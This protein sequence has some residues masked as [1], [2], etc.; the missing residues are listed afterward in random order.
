MFSHTFS[1]CRPLN[2][3]MHMYI[4]TCVYAC[5]QRHGTNHAIY[6]NMVRRE[7]IIRPPHLFVSSGAARHVVREPKG[8]RRQNFGPSFPPLEG[9]PLSGNPRSTVSRR[10]PKVVLD[11]LPQRRERRIEKSR[12]K[13]RGEFYPETNNLNLLA[14][15]TT[16]TPALVFIVVVDTKSHVDLM[17]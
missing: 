8:H 9:S 10:G 7:T 1:F 4:H 15:P 2:Y 12:T 14:T 17:R 11:G 5:E 3:W 13:L 16:S 6:G